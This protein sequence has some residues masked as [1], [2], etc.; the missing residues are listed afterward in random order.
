MQIHYLKIEGKLVIDYVLRKIW[1][2]NITISSNRFR[3]GIDFLNL[4][5]LATYLCNPDRSSHD[6]DHG[7][8]RPGCAPAVHRHPRR[9][10]SGSAH[11][12]AAAVGGTLIWRAPTTTKASHPRDFYP[13]HRHKPSHR[14]RVFRRDSCVRLARAKKTAK[15]RH[16]F[17]A[18]SWGARRRRLGSAVARCINSESPCL[19][20]A[21]M[22]P[23]YMSRK[24][25][26]F[27]TD[28]FDT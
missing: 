23:V 25:R 22:D 27:R 10:T 9:K 15:R 20:K 5:P 16:P 13:F 1:E 6:T 28:K 4:A 26:K 14:R 21:V 18:T 17:D 2:I 11:L 7:R 3:I 8:H 19:R 24:I 12:V